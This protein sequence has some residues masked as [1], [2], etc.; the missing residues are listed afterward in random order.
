[1]RHTIVKSCLQE[2]DCC[3]PDLIL[4]ANERNICMQVL[5]LNPGSE[6]EGTSTRVLYAEALQEESGQ[7]VESSPRLHQNE[8][9]A[10]T[11][12]KKHHAFIT[13]M[14]Q[15]RECFETNNKSSGARLPASKN[16]KKKKKTR[17]CNFDRPR[18]ETIMT[19]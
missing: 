18:L 4:N 1:M 5:A 17:G 8:E 19:K 12:D 3:Q 9:L 14:P 16:R 15:N 7:P 13:Y 10:A 11:Y 6:C 2:H